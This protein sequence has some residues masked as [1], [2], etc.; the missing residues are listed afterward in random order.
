MCVCVV[1]VCVCV[2]YAILYFIYFEKRVWIWIRVSL[3]QTCV[4]VVL[5]SPSESVKTHTDN[6]R[7][8]SGSCAHMLSVC[9]CA[10]LCFDL[11]NVF[12]SVCWLGLTAFFIFRLLISLGH[13]LLELFLSSH[14]IQAVDVFHTRFVCRFVCVQRVPEGV[15]CKPTWVI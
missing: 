15:L 8:I 13:I 2:K 10:C 3:Y 6:T 1:C 7:V 4:F 9:V 14:I 11:L 12:V 5:Y